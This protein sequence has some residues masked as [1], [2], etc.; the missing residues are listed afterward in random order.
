LFEE[1]IEADFIVGGNRGATIRRVSEGTCQRMA[2]AM[3]CRVKVQMAVSQ[4]DAAVGLAGDVRVMRH[5]QDG[6]AGVVQ[7]A[8]NLDDDGF[9]GFVKISGGLVGE[10]NLRLVD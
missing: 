4:F 2:W 3:L 5:H 1:M 8:E 9:V 7:F 6:V 10:N